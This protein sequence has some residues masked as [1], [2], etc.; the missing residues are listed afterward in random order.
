MLEEHFRVMYERSLEYN[1]K[2]YIYCADFEKAF[3]RVN[4]YKFMTILQNMEVD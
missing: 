3:D 2:V 1:K 4:R